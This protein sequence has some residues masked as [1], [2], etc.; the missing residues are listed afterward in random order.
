MPKKKPLTK[1]EREAKNL[2]R[3][4][5][6]ME[7][8]KLKLEKAKSKIKKKWTKKDFAK[9][10]KESRELSD[11]TC[12]SSGIVKSRYFKKKNKQLNFRT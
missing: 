2:A 10:Y 12:P 11:Y 7:S 5:K 8:K 9:Y 6:N 1:E 3:N 4:L